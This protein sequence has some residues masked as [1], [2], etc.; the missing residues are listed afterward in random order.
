M[1]NHEES[2]RVEDWLKIARTDWQADVKRDLMGA[3]KLIN[4][5]FPEEELHA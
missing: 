4:T 1:S 2:G 3:K 5:I